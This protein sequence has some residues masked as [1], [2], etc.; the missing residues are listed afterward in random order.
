MLNALD[1]TVGDGDLGITLL[2]AFRELEED[3]R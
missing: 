3:Q 2:K 1:G